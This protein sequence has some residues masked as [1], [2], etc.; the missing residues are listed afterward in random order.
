MKK[1]LLAFLFFIA[2]FSLSAQTPDST[3]IKVDSVEKKIETLINVSDS[4]KATD[5]IKYCVIGGLLGLNFT[6]SSFTNWA[7]GGENAISATALVNLFANFKRNKT[8][9]ENNLDLAYGLL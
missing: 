3:K 4:L 8:T 7:A 2:C 5:T 1:H 9:W 6:Q